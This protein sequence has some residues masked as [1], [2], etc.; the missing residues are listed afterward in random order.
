MTER[1]QKLSIYTLIRWVGTILA[2]G[3]VVYLLYQQGWDQ[4]WGA[5]RQIG[6]ERFAIAIGLM[7]V[8]RFMM[9]GR[10]YVLMVSSEEKFTLVDGLKLTFAGLF[11]NNFL[12]STVGG[13]VVRFA[14]AV[15]AGY[16][17]V[18]SAASLIVDRLV[19]MFGMALALPIG[20]YR[21]FQVPNPFASYTNLDVHMFA[22]FLPVSVISFMEKIRD[23]GKALLKRLL[24]AVALWIRQ[25]RAL[26][27]S[28]LFTLF[29]M[30]CFFGILWVLLDGMNDPVPYWLIG[31]LWSLVYFVT[32][33]P[34]SING[35]G[36]QEVAITFA[37]STLGG[38]SEDSAVILALL[39]RT[40][41]MLA[42][43]PGA[44]F[45]SGILPE[46]RKQS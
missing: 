9:V 1:Q 17:G 44:L 33:I 11:A 27:S 38:A 18:I 3:L 43:L 13:D 21:A 36:V 4:I 23:K 8:S 24:E 20:L 6:V 30:V 40:L 32:L 45:I 41:V 25:P 22:G 10:W 37:F 16:D 35:L 42:S 26:L 15:Q 29:H 34:I 31:G 2:F 7:I 14:G 28:L 19:G 46:V 5:V 39:F 12:P